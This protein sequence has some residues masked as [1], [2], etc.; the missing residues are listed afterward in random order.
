MYIYIPHLFRHFSKEDT[1]MTGRHIERHS[2]VLNIREMQIRTTKRYNL[3]PIRMPIIKKSISNLCCRRKTYC[4]WE[5]S[6]EILQKTKSRV[7]IWSSNPTSLHILRQNNNSK[8]Y[9]HLYVHS[10]TIYNR[11]DMETTAMF[12]NRWMDKEDVEY[13][14]M[15]THTHTHRNTTHP[16][17]KMMNG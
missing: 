13:T 12:T 2:T 11:Q 8:R 16:W 17:K 4:W 1:Q 3:T 6:M 14:H 5:N 9:K 10:S 15:H 7:A